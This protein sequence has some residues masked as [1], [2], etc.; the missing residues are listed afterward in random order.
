MTKPLQMQARRAF[1]QQIVPQYQQASVDQKRQMVEGFVAIT[2]YARKYAVWLLNHAEQIVQASHASQLSYAPEVLQALVFAWKTLNQICAK[3]LIP[4]LPDLLD[5]LEQGEYVHLNEKN[6]R[7]LLSLSAATADRL[8][9]T[10]RQVRPQSLSTTKAGPLLKQQIPIRTFAAWNEAQPAFLEIDLV[11]HCG[12]HVDGSFLYTLTLTDVATGWT[13]CLPLL[14][15]GQEAVLEGLQHARMLFPFPILGI[16]TDNGGEFINEIVLAYC[17]REQITFT[18]GRPHEKRDQCFI[19]QK[20]GVVVRQVV[21]RDRFE[22]E[23]A[24]RQLAELYQALRLYVNYFQPSMKL[25]TKTYEG[26]TVRRTYDAAKTPCQR[27]LLSGVLSLSQQDELG[28]MARSLDPVRLFQQLQQLQHAVFR[29][30]VGASSTQ[31]SPLLMFARECCLMGPLP[32]PERRPDPAEASVQQVRQALEENTTVLT[33]RRTRNDPFAGQWK[34]IL[35]WMQADPTRS[36]GDIF[37]QL[38]A[39]FP[40]RYQPLQIRTLQRGIRKIRAYLLATKP[41]HAPA[42]AIQGPHVSPAEAP[43]EFTT[44]EFPPFPCPASPM[45]QPNDPLFTK[46]KTLSNRR[47]PRQEAPK[48]RTM[49]RTTHVASHA[50]SLLSMAKQ[51]TPASNAE[52]PL[53]LEQAMETYLQAHQRAGHHPKTL[54]WHQTALGQLQQ[55][56]QAERALFQV[57]DLT[58]ADMCGWFAFLQQKQTR[59]GKPLTAQTIETYARSARAFCNWL[60][61]QGHLLRTSLAEFPLPPADA[62]VFPLLDLEGFEQIVIACQPATKQ[63]PHVEQAVARNRAILWLCFDTGMRTSELCALR[64]GDLD[65]SLGIITVRGEGARQR[66]LAL[67]QPALRHLLVYLDQFRPDE[68][69]LSVYGRV[70]EDHLF[71]S[72]TRL[73]LTTNM[74]ALLFARLRKRAGLGDKSISPQNLRRNFALR[75]VQTGGNPRALQELLGY[76]SITQVKHYLD[77]YDQL[78]HRNT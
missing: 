59:A 66:R 9:R 39:L 60:V 63:G 54:E 25:Q 75:Y 73:P 21:G 10:H 46:I 30:A 4:F 55:Y 49:R 65:R 40:G 37:R 68:E 23:Q 19:E 16:D 33:W 8:L 77:W 38:Q 44:E 27:L 42:E 17:A 45:S 62:P 24:A 5:P 34:Q 12:P 11:A 69:E 26:R 52:T 35:A 36:S 78:V 15:R 67:G 2:G 51:D 28:M 13:E 50:K 70:G 7:Q 48:R 58:E 41:P 3:R 71:L 32:T 31:S 29:Y 53:T 72:E 61:S 47:Q 18:R 1:L 22:G 6:R 74:L 56:M 76:G 64:L 43:S 20:N 57:Q 14:H